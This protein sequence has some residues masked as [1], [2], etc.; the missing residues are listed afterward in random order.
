MK[1][2]VWIT[3]SF[4]EDS[5]L[6]DQLS[7]PC[8]F[9]YYSPYYFAGDREKDILKRC[10]QENLDAFYQTL[11]E[12]GNSLKAKGHNFY[13]FKNSA[14]IEHINQ[15]CS[16]YGFD[17]LV[18]DQPLFAMWHTID[19][20]QL[21]VP[22]QFVDSDL[23]DDQC[24]KMTAKS[25]WMTHVK[26]ID[27]YCNY[28]WNDDIQTFDID[29]PISTYP[30]YKSNW[31]VNPSTVQIRAKA[32][33]PRYGLTRDNHKGQ[34]RLST[35]FQNG[36][37]DPH[38]VFFSIAKEFQKDGA[39]FTLNEGNHAAMLRQF[40]F[41]EITIIQARRANLTME[42]TP[43]EW[44][45]QFITA[46]SLQNLKDRINPDSRLT[47]EQI[48]TATT[49]DELIDKILSESFQVGVMP[50]RA[51]MFFAGWMFY[52]A[53]SGQQALEW[54][55]DVFDLLLI[56]GQCPTNYTQCTSA[57]NMQYGRV[58]L[59]NRDRVKQLLSYDTI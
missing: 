15:L 28:R 27:T 6:T 17:R 44:A 9:V 23:I 36:V 12:F 33:A 47:L 22:Y 26:Q 16:K 40:A 5:R 35:A 30:K 42:N 1:T 52:N 3:H 59:L 46:T 58:M 7:G 29:E 56:D 53:P 34:T 4:R 55:I 19:L 50:N 48:K 13:V 10:S 39:D 43:M 37:I 32:I 24:F 54:L 2:L 25:R 31:L 45:Q 14:P 51:R 57:M 49:G 21:S 11:H 8:T 38:N 41:R 18:I 20:L